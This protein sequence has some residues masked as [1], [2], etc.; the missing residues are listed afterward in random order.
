MKHNHLFKRVTDYSVTL[1]SILFMQK[2]YNQMAKIVQKKEKNL[3]AHTVCSK[4]GKYVTTG[5]V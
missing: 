2:K 3:H 5:I 1:F 4:I